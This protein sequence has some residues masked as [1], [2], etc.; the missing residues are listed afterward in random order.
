[1]AHTLYLDFVI[2]TSS[3]RSLF[4]NNHYIRSKGTELVLKLGQE[5]KEAAFFFSY[6]EDQSQIRVTNQNSEH[7]KT[8]NY[9]TISTNLTFP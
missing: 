4:R 3:R 2:N 9:Y 8:T 5:K 7:Y 1:M 6:F